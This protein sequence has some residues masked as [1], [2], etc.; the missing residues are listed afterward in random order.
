MPEQK[1]LRM[2]KR[3]VGPNHIGFRVA[4]PKKQLAVVAVANNANKPKITISRLSHDR[5]NPRKTRQA[6]RG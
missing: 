3:A 6:F 2:P 4:S 1:T 5:R